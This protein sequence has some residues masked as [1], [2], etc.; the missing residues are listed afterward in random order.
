MFFFLI[1]FRNC[2]KSYAN[3]VDLLRRP[4]L[5]RLNLVCTFCYAP[6]MGYQ[7]KS[8]NGSRYPI[9]REYV[10]SSSFVCLCVRS[11][12][13]S[14]DMLRA[15]ILLVALFSL[16]S[17]D[18]LESLFEVSVVKAMREAHWNLTNRGIVQN[19]GS[20]FSFCKVTMVL[21]VVTT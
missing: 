6:F 15:A 5:Q 18:Y 3:S 16:G 11:L 4:V 19:C 9:Q 21:T 8:I 17:C 20:T 12:F 2:C 7:P 14:F 10:S 13:F 1:C